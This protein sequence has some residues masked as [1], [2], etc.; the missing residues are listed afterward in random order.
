MDTMHG[1]AGHD[2]EW[3][4]LLTGEKQGRIVR[5]D[6]YTTRWLRPVPPT[7]KSRSDA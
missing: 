7:T 1:G 2:G 3:I 4:D 5:L 6:A